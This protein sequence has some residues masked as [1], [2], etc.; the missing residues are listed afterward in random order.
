MMIRLLLLVMILATNSNAFFKDAPVSRYA[1][2]NMDKPEPDR[3][4]YDFSRDAICQ[5]CGDRSNT[6]L[7]IN[8]INVNRQAIRHVDIYTRFLYGS[9]FYVTYDVVMNYDG[10]D[11]SSIVHK[12]LEGDISHIAKKH[13][14][15]ELCIDR[16]NRYAQVIHYNNKFYINRME[17][18]IDTFSDDKT[19]CIYILILVAILFGVCTLVVWNNYPALK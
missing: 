15:R 10:N 11:T 2:W 1:N 14:C 6:L 17:D 3:Y 18:T 16:F 13:I 7:C 4:D 19:R 12:L 8:C 9:T 5:Q